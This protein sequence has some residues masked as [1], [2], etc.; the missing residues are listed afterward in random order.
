VAKIR[1]DFYG[2]VHAGGLVL[3]AG[4]VIPDGVRVGGH[5]VEGGIPVGPTIVPVPEG[6]PSD[7]GVEPLTVDEVSQAGLL[8]IPVDVHPERVRGALFGFEVGFEAA[9]N[10][11]A[12]PEDVETP[13]EPEEPVKRRPGRPRKN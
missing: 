9:S 1:T 2:V 10:R 7:H 13:V 12:E 3:R 4:D 8:G 6:V 11:P 5:L